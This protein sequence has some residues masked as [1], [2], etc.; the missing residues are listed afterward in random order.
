MVSGKNVDSKFAERIGI[1]V[2]GFFD[3]YLKGENYDWT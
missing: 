1:S 3:E 2:V